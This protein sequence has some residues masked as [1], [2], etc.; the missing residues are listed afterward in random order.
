MDSVRSLGEHQPWQEKDHLWHRWYEQ[1]S[2]HFRTLPLLPGWST[3]PSQPSS[4]PM[5]LPV[6]EL[7]RMP[8]SRSTKVKY[9]SFFF[10]RNL[11]CTIWVINIAPIVPFPGMN[12][13]CMSSMLT[14][15]LMYFSITLSKTF[16]RWSSNFKPLKCGKPWNNI[17]MQ[18]VCSEITTLKWKW[19]GIYQ[20]DIIYL[21]LKLRIKLNQIVVVCFLFRTCS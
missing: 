8:F 7:Y 4:M 19:T 2:L 9:K 3:L 21:P 20:L 12:P 13:N 10:A 5:L 17:Y 16:M 15:S 1:R 6:V 14:A 11:S 18:V